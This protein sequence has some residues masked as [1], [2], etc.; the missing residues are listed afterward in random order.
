MITIILAGGLG[1]RMNS[2]LPKVLHKIGD[3]PMIYY[4]IQN[5]LAIGSIRIL[6]VVGKYKNHIKTEI[7]SLFPDTS[8]WLEYIDQETPLGTGHAIQCAVPYLLKNQLPLDTNILILSGD[9]PLITEKTLEQLCAYP[10]T[11]LITK[12]EQPKGCGR[13]IFAKDKIVKI[14]E[15]KDCSE[16]ERQIEH[17]N[18]GIYNITVKT[19]LDTVPYILNQN[20]ANEFYLTDFVDLAIEKK[21]ELNYFEL[22]EADQYQVININTEADLVKANEILFVK[23]EFR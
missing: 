1:K 6:I 10:N 14:I 23:Q 19:L 5:A 16:E 9:V 3:K 2:T 15:E 12:L 11:I 13:I 22:L 18:C 21:I 17:V 7:D 4:V 20:K 8:S